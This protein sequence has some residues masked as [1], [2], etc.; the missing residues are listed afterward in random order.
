MNEMIRNQGNG[1]S[2]YSLLV[3]RVNLNGSRTLLCAPSYVPKTG[4]FLAIIIF[5]YLSEDKGASNL[6]LHSLKTQLDESKEL[7]TDWFCHHLKLSNIIM[8]ECA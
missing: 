5:L 8:V 1:F 7:H 2:H 4:K 6:Y 3:I